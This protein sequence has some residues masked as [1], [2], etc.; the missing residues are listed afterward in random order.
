MNWLDFLI[1]IP[2]AWGAFKGLVK[3][4]VAELLGIIG[5]ILGLYLANQFSG[6][7]SAALNWSGR[8]SGILAFA[9]LFILVVLV[10]YLL[11]R[12]LNKTLDV[13]K[14]QWLNKLG[15]M[16]FGALKWALV[17]SVIL[18]IWDLVDKA[19]PIFKSDVKQQ[20]TLY[21][22][23]SGLG[24]G[25]ANLNDEPIQNYLNFKTDSIH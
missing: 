10:F 19:Y 9:L 8:F 15:G 22:V 18:Y 21:P 4:L 1:L 24:R 5:I 2:M 11:I 13:I 12:L 20:S 14:L 3:G 23:I 6:H 17:F 7:L 16:A 25:L